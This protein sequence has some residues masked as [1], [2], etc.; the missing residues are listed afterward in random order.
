MSQKPETVFRQ[1]QVIPFLRTLPNTTFFSIQQLAIVGDPDVMLC[2]N[3]RFVALELKDV[4]EKAS[5]LQLYK[6][7]S[8]RRAGGVALVASRENWESTKLI[9]TKLDQGDYDD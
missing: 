9:L 8:V 1:N 4:G 6:L 2:M 5:K 3:G 7:E